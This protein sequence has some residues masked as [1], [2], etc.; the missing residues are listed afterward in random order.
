MSLV[1]RRIDPTPM[2]CNI[3]GIRLNSS[4]LSASPLT[5]DAPGPLLISLEETA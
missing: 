2:S 1:T 4:F 3:E 5:R